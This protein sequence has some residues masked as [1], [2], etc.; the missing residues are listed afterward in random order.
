MSEQELTKNLAITQ[1]NYLY[2]A[3]YY[4]RIKNLA[5]IDPGFLASVKTHKDALCEHIGR[6]QR[7]IYLEENTQ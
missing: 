6:L 5:R 3:N 1:Y 2:W 4:V 7:L